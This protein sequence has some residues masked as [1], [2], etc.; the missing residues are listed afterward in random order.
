MDIY[1]FDL[2]GT[3]SFAV[4]GAFSAIKKKMDVFGVLVVALFTAVGG[5]TVRDLLIGKGPVIWLL[6]MNY[7]YV[8]IF[9]V[10]TVFLMRKHL[11]KYTQPLFLFDS[12]GIA[13]CTVIGVQKTMALGMSPVVAIIMGTVS[14]V[15]GGIIR[16]LLCNEIPLVLQR[17]IYATACMIG[18]FQYLLL[19]LILNDSN[20]LMLLSMMTITMIRVLAVKLKWA[21]PVLEE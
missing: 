4:S 17:E 6:D 18:G 10:F 13:T 5:G 16:D 3:F 9:S 11:Y 19:S 2:L 21:L 14:A 12:L 8:T 7:L 1:M 15:F 20:M